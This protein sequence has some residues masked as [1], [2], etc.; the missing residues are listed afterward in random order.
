MGMSE[1][2][3]DEMLDAVAEQIADLMASFKN[4]SG[5][6]NIVLGPARNAGSIVEVKQRM[7]EF[8]SRIEK[9]LDDYEIVANSVQH[10][11]EQK[12]ETL[13]AQNKKENMESIDK[14]DKL[15][16]AIIKLSNEIKEL[17]VQLALKK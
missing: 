5:G 2:E 14:I 9:K 6:E 7:S 8:E 1:S 13:S 10:Q 4:Q 16:T 15:R 12:F 11:L 17:K 3:K